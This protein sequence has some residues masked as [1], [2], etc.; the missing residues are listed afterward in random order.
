MTAPKSKEKGYKWKV[1]NQAK[2]RIKEVKW[3]NTQADNMRDLISIKADQP[4]LGPF[5]WWI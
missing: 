1:G 2:F 3:E 4:G 5:D